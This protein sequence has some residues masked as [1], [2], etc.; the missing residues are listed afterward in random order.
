[1]QTALH[2]Q[3]YL[4]Y[5]YSHYKATDSL[6]NSQAPEVSFVYVKATQGTNLA[7][8]SFGSNWRALP[9]SRQRNEFLAARII[10]IVRSASGGTAQA[11]RFLEYVT[12]YGGSYQGS[13]AGDRPRMG[14]ILSYVRGPMDYKPKS[15]DDI[16]NTTQQFLRRLQRATSRTPLLYTNRS[17]LSD[18]EFEPM[19]RSTN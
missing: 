3:F 5:R 17:F 18:M 6:W 19:H 12:L 2:E 7:D 14:Q 4:R 9:R 10:L 11:D 15:A 13:T 8:K 1:M 16:I